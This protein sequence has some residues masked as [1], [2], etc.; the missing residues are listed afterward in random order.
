MQGERFRQP[1][2]ISI[3]VGFVVDLVQRKILLLLLVMI[4]QSQILDCTVRLHVYLLLCLHI[5]KLQLDNISFVVEVFK[6]KSSWL[7]LAMVCVKRVIWWR[8]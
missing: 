8:I 2:L 5:V 6:D 1:I 4:R 7:R 3:L